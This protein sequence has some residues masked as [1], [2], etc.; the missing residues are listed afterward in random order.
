MPYAICFSSHGAED[1][2][3]FRAVFMTLE[4]HASSFL[5]STMLQSSI[6]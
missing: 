5:L 2:E 3:V 4:M 6:T 1:R